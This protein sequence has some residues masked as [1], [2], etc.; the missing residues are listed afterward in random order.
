MVLITTWH[1]AQAQL[2]VIN[3]YAT[4]E[5]ILQIQLQATLNDNNISHQ[6]KNLNHLR[7]KWVALSNNRDLGITD[8]AKDI[9]RLQMHTGV[10]L[11]L[12]NLICGYFGW[13]AIK[14]SRNDG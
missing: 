6:Q 12:F 3:V 14:F 1:I 8:L 11:S 13:R 2:S 4:P 9:T 5:K 10:E 7:E